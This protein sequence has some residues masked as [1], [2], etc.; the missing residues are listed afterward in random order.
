L[1]FIDIKKDSVG[2]EGYVKRKEEKRPQINIFW[3][4]HSIPREKR[5]FHYHYLIIICA[6]L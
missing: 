2:I 5:N 6:F 1:A 3:S 4:A